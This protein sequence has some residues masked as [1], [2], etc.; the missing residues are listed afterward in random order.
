MGEAE[1]RLSLHKIKMSQEAY[2]RTFISLRN[3]LVRERYGLL[4]IEIGD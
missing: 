3:L 4:K 1:E 2:E